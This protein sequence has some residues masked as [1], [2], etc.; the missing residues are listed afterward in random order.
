MNGEQQTV[1]QL[2]LKIELVVLVVKRGYVVR[3]KD[4][5]TDVFCRVPFLWP[6]TEE[7]VK[8]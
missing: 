8:C 5:K 2:A 3:L 1:Y 6:R 7:L 4:S